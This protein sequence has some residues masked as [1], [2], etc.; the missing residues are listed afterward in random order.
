MSDYYSY[1]DPKKAGAGQSFDYDGGSGTGWFWAIVVVL[2]LVV[3]LA[4]GGSRGVVEDGAT[5]PLAV[6]DPTAAPTA[7]E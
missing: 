3:L 4:I 7:T 5:A 6:P 2:A 1:R